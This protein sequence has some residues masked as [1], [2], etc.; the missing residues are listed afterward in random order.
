MNPALESSSG[1]QKKK[2]ANNVEVNLDSSSETKKEKKSATSLGARLIPASVLAQQRKS[3]Q[4][5][6]VVDS[7]AAH[8]SGSSSKP[9]LSQSQSS[10]R[11]PTTS[12]GGVGSGSHEKAAPIG[13]SMSSGASDNASISSSVSGSSS[14]ASGGRGARGGGGRGVRSNK[15]SPAIVS[16]KV[17]NDI[18]RVINASAASVTPA[19]PPTL[20]ASAKSYVPGIMGAGKDAGDVNPY[21]PVPPPAI[22]NLGAREKAG[23]EAGVGAG[24]G[25]GMGAIVTAGRKTKKGAEG[26]GGGKLGGASS[27]VATAGEGQRQRK[28]IHL[29]TCVICTNA[30]EFVAVGTCDH[31]VCSVCALRLRVKRKDKTCV[32]CRTEL[33]MMVVCRPC[34]ST[35]TDADI[36][37]FA[38]W[39][40]NSLDAPSPGCDIDIMSGLVF[41]HCRPHFTALEAMRSI[42]CPVV[43]CKQRLPHEKALLKHTRTAHNQLMCALC[44]ENRPLFVSEQGIFSEKQLKQHMESS[45]TDGQGLSGHPECQFCRQRFFDAMSLY[46]HMQNSHCTCPLCPVEHQF[47]F[48]HKPSNLHSH[49]KSAHFVCDSCSQGDHALGPVAFGTASEYS[50]HLASIHGVSRA[51]RTLLS[52]YFG[53]DGERSERK[54]DYQSSHTNSRGPG[55]QGVASSYVDLDMT[56]LDPNRTARRAPKNGNDRE[57]R[58][59]REEVA[60]LVPEGMR[61]AGRISGSGMFQRTAA[62]DLVQRASDE[63]HARSAAGRLRNGTGSWSTPRGT[64]AFPTLSSGAPKDK[65]ASLAV[66]PG[67][68]P[69][70][71]VSQQAELARKKHAEMQNLEAQR[72]EVERKRA[73]RNQLLAESFGVAAPQAYLPASGPAA[74]SSASS[75]P[76]FA[77]VLRRP[78]YTP[79]MVQWANKDLRELVKIERKLETLIKTADTSVSFKPMQAG[80]RAYIHALAR[81]YGA[82]SYEY[83]Q[84]PRRYVSVVKTAD[85]A[86]PAV[87]L[88]TAAVEKAMPL[89]DGLRNQDLPLLYFHLLSGYFANTKNEGPT[90]VEASA[91]IS[92]NTI[93][94]PH[95]GASRLWTGGANISQV[96]GALRA[97][98]QGAGVLHEPSMVLA[99]V[100]PHGAHGVV[101][102]LGDVRAASLAQYLLASEWESK[103]AVR[104]ARGTQRVGAPV[105]DPHLLDLFEMETG[106]VPGTQGE[107]ERISQATTGCTT[108][109][110]DDGGSSSSRSGAIFSGSG[111]DGEDWRSKGKGNMAAKDLATRMMLAKHEAQLLER[112]KW[113]KEIQAAWD[114]DEEESSD[115]KNITA[116]G[117]GL[118]GDDADGVAVTA[119]T[120]EV[121]AGADT[122]IIDRK[123]VKPLL[124]SMYALPWPVLNQATNSNVLNTDGNAYDIRLL[125]NPEPV[126]KKLNLAPR[127]LPLPIFA[128]QA[129]LPEGGSDIIAAK[130]TEKGLKV[131]RPS[132]ATMQARQLS[133]GDREDALVEV[134]G[135][136]ALELA[137]HTIRSNK[138]GGP[139]RSSLRAYLDSDSDDEQN[140]DDPDKNYFECLIGADGRPVFAKNQTSKYAQP[141][142]TKYPLPQPSASTFDT[143]VSQPMLGIT[144]SWACP[145]CTFV[146]ESDKCEM[147]DAPRS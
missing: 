59:D 24:G 17:Q 53:E 23:V 14:G 60:N 6:E 134:G 56:Q 28:D 77:A 87:L 124:A 38:S 67:T 101:L 29:F 48:Y 140:K 16:A 85:T 94:V 49:L 51:P 31:A 103:S 146:N 12:A 133:R 137:A 18:T 108:R 62:D 96:V 71:L 21:P 111:A 32:V 20:S 139:T 68:H 93:P 58:S 26:K 45:A 25:A 114:S 117:S 142:A 74:G 73:E 30:V 1:T 57:S 8:S 147:C 82:N 116:N 105:E 47:R 136:L 72:Q 63:A 104:A 123:M 13:D 125:P 54:G 64:D 102:E 144:Y 22:S 33:A 15:R 40:V 46:H 44:L 61:I 5:V 88:S 35:D 10:G 75:A 4:K 119:E 11:K 131:W 141:V 138:I 130:S 36:P 97:T 132:A 99:S 79:N 69:L 126:R 100:R 86:I 65:A 83:D 34:G 121:E 90:T 122:E 81:Y 145:T 27:K 84:E 52:I 128:A 7:A 110:E 3:T 129:T 2:G 91:A 107:S 80:P 89:Y 39:G 106:F 113:E 135:A 78:L 19:K 37:Q 70:S 112:K 120:S 50:S 98:L 95:T 42:I 43:D 127:T 118:V 92:K 41:M 76:A 66:K 55:G 115:I 109:P 143:L 9:V